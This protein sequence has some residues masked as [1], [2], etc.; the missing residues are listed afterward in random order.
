MTYNIPINMC[1]RDI[2]KAIKEYQ[3]W[4]T[5]DTPPRNG[6][7]VIFDTGKFVGEGYIADDGFWYRYAGYRAEDMLGEVV[8]WKPMPE[9]IDLGGK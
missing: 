8:R 3:E 2:I 6:E 1:K 7:R 5:I 4:R 9:P